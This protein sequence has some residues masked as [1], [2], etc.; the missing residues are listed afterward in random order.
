MSELTFN[1][2][3][4]GLKKI[5]FAGDLSRTGKS[6]IPLLAAFILLSA[7][8]AHAFTVSKDGSADY[9]S[10]KEALNDQATFGGTIIV[11]PDTYY[12]SNL[13]I[14]FNR[15]LQAENLNNPESTIIDATGSGKPVI[16]AGYAT[17]IG[18]T[19]RGGARLMRVVNRGAASGP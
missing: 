15:T 10:I 2:A 1:N 11:K 4:K 14:G 3:I 16:S 7:A 13:S 9:T 18:F 5:S 17:I 12:E 8:F 6:K 19:I